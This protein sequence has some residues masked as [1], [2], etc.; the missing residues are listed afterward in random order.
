MICDQNGT[1]GYVGVEGLGVPELVGAL[2]RAVPEDVDH[3]VVVEVAGD[4]TDARPDVV[5]LAQ[6]EPP[7]RPDSTMNPS[8]RVPVVVLCTNA[9]PRASAP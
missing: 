4:G 2:A 6:L 1:R 8:S 7:A 9:N 3:A 5:A